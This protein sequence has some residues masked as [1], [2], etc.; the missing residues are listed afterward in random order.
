MPRIPVLFAI[1]C[2]TSVP[3]LAGPL[4][5]GLAALE[6]GRLARAFDLIS[7]AAEAGIGEAQF[8]L[9]KLYLDGQGTE[10]DPR[11]AVMW[12]ERAAANHYR[13]ANLLLGKIYASGMGVEM[14]AAK[15]AE[16]LRRA[17]ELATPED[18]D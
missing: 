16:H 14:D 4:E 15:S 12:L 10:A 17:A 6:R 13:K 2:L 1:L 11:Q 3:L 5:E 7:E 18:D 9:G 8:R